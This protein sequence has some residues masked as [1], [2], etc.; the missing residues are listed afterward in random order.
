MRG[1]S[2]GDGHG[3]TAWRRFD[4]FGAAR[5]Q[6]PGLELLAEAVAVPFD[7]GG[8]GVVE[9]AI[10]DRGRDHGIAEH[11]A[12]SPEALVTGE[13]DGPALVATGDE[14]EEEVGT[15]AVDGDIADL[16]DDEQTAVVPGA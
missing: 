6:Q 2:D 16:V 9:Q 7:V 12:P 1:R 15:L 8:D 4:A 14:L 11:L 10:E 5:L 3:L 13:D